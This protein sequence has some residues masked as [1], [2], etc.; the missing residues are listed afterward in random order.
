[1]N[2]RQRN[3]VVLIVL[4]V[5]FVSA[6]ASIAVLAFVNDLQAGQDLGRK[7]RQDFQAEQR[8][9]LCAR[10]GITDPSKIGQVTAVCDGYDTLEESYQTERSRAHPS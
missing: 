7:Q 9:I 1:M 8:F 10:E 2:D 6:M 3:L 4:A 5:C